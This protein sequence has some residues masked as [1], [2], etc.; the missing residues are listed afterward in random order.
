M[1]SQ[2]EKSTQFTIYG[3]SG[4]LNPGNTC[5]MNSA[6][7][8]FSHLYPLTNYFFN[9]KERILQTLR[10]N[11]RK[12]LKDK[13][14][15]DVQSKKSNVP[16]SLREK[17]QS[18]S[19]DPSSITPEEATII[20]NYTI[21]AKLINLLENMWTKNCT[22]LPTSFRKVFTE[23]RDK[24]FFGNQQHDSEEAYSCILQ[25]MQEELFE[26][27][28]IYFTANP[29]IDN[30][31]KAKLS[32]E[33]KLK[34][35]DDSDEEKISLFMDLNNLVQS[36]P[37]ENLTLLA[38]EEMKEHFSSSYSKITDIFSGFHHSTLKCPS[39]DF[40]SNK[41]DPFLHLSLPIPP[42]VPIGLTGLNKLV[43]IEDCMREYCREEILDEKNLWSCGKCNKKV[44]AVKK[45]QL[46]TAP[47]I[48]VFQFKRFSHARGSKDSRLI[49]YPLEKLNIASMISPSQT[50]RN[51]CYTYSLQCIINHAGNLDGGHYYTCC[52]DEDSNRWFKFNDH[53]VEA[54]NASEIIAGE[55]YLLF[56]MQD[57][58][59]IL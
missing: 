36:H 5:Y 21:S 54:I 18:E 29:L 13:E 33:T 45:F 6:I 56:Y 47:K 59:I 15:F 3:L 27:K 10:T 55:A 2:P 46:W 14:A 12:I 40:I 26:K 57:S 11:A 31:K 30:F 53:D 48:L 51:N 50:D 7:Q 35:L 49:R 39:C 20:Y 34:S 37:N 4:I 32:L 25:Q 16:L 43:T 22:I 44:R 24:C 42:P 23:A 1:L 58:M 19:F 41:F 17:I 28:N 52:R 9:N 38:Y 8:A